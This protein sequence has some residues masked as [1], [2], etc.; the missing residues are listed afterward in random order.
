[1]S[2]SSTPFYD[3][4][5]VTIYHADC[6]DLLPRLPDGCVDF[7]LTDPPY[8]VNYTGRWDGD[9]QPI[10]GDADPSWL[11]PVFREVWRVMKD[12]T[13]CLSFYGWPQAERFLTTWK[14]L[15]FRPVSHLAFVKRVWGLGRFTRGQ[16]ET[17]YL[18]A[19]GRPARP[20]Q[21]VSDAVPWEREA[22]SFHPNQRPVAALVPF[23]LAYAPENGLV[24]DPFMGSGS[25]LR[26]AKD[27]GCRAVGVEVERAYCE[28]AARRMDQKVLFAHPRP[29]PADGSDEP[30]LF[31]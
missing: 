3:R 11:L 19:K 6:R 22:E 10:A 12:N 4:D 24:L 28:L 2:G 27:C 1:M 7:V 15:G 8:L 14:A 29:I 26:A 31:P 30:G 17:A 18:L 13:L 16:H 5:G 9:R 23:I 20:A 21:A 25:T